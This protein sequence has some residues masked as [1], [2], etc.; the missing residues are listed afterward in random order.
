MV[1][2]KTLQVS[3]GQVLVASAPSTHVV[4]VG[5]R[6]APV[7]GVVE[8]IALSGVISGNAA[9][10]STLS[11]KIRNGSDPGNMAAGTVV[12]R[13]DLALTDGAVFEVQVTADL[14]R[15]RYLDAYFEIAGSDPSV[16]ISAFF[17]PRGMSQQLTAYAN[18]VDF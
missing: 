1:I 14:L 3:A 8:P 5:P 4:D 7:G 6:P 13:G 2:D 18:A 9:T 10:A 15:H 16:I 17:G 11:V 12:G